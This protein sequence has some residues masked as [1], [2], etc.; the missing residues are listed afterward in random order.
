LV[1][2]NPDIKVVRE[3]PASLLIDGDN[4]QG[5]PV[6]TKAIELAVEK[7]KTSG[8]CIT[9]VKNSNHCGMLG[10]YSL[11][12][13]EHDLISMALTAAPANM[14]PWGGRERFLGTNPFC[15]GVPTGTEGPIVFDAATSVAA[16]GKIA[17]ALKNNMKIPIGWAINKDG[18]PTTDPQE[19]LEGLVLPVGGPKGYGI[20]FFVEVLSSIFTG[21]NIGP[22]ISD[23][24]L[25]FEKP[26]NV[27]HY[28]MLMRADLFMDLQ[29]FKSRMDNTIRE[30][31]KLPLMEGTDKIYMPGEL[32]F[33][34]QDERSREGIPV[35]K[36]LLDEFE[37]L[38]K[39]YGVDL[40]ILV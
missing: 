36:E 14:A 35:T 37:A 15:Y 9:G 6:A 38:A 27:G 1:N 5:I 21:A 24:Y 32:E 11:Y 23:L 34:K 33:I 12:A 20:A 17:Y 3:T 7:A 13:A 26:Q 31:R 4:G 25:N 30:I 19:G 8:V 16:R 39:E 29:E 40:S 18:K 10:A 28:F 22:Q 2:K